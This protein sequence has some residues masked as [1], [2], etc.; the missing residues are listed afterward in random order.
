MPGGRRYRP[1]RAGQEKGWGRRECL[2][3]KNGRRIGREGGQAG[4]EET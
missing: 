4:T 2:R 3:V 1:C